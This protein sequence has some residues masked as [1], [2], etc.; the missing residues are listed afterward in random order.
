MVRVLELEDIEASLSLTINS[1]SL[2]VSNYNVQCTETNSDFSTYTYSVSSTPVLQSLSQQSV[3]AGDMLVI[4]LKGISETQNDNILL[5][6]GNTGLTCFSPNPPILSTVIMSP[7]TSVSTTAST[8]SDHTT[9]VHCT[10]P[11]LPAGMYRPLLHVAGRGWGQSSLESTVVTVHP[12]ITSSPSSAS[13]SLRGGL[14]LAMG[15]R[16][17]FDSDVLRTRVTIGNTPCRVESIDTEGMLTCFTQAAVDDGYSALIRASLPLAY[18]SLQTDYYRSNNS[19]LASD[20]LSFLRNSGSLGVRANASIHGSI[21]LRQEGISGNSLTDQ[22]IGFTE[23]AFLQVPALEE[24]LSPSGFAMDFWVRVPLSIQHYRIL[25]NASSSCEDAA[26]GFMV[27]L[28][29]CNQVE[30]WLASG[31]QFQEE[32]DQSGSG[33]DQFQEDINLFASGENLQQFLE[34]NATVCS[35]ISDVSQCSTSCSGYMDTSGLMLPTG[36]WHIIRSSPTNLSDWN[37]V[38]ISWKANTIRD[39]V[40]NLTSTDCMTT[41]VCNGMQEL[42]I[43]GEYDSISSTYQRANTGIEIGGSSSIALGTTG[44]WNGMA[45]FNGYIDEVAYYD[46][47]LELSEINSRVVH[48]TQET[49]PIVLTVEGF[50]GVGTGSVPNLI[51]TPTTNPPLP[52]EVINW[53][54]VV[55]FEYTYEDSVMLQFGWIQ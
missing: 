45:P 48:G 5:F 28:N 53:E 6:G 54:S 38:Y 52:P 39:S 40:N 17:L 47:P 33:V 27:M 43:N 29:P 16:G 51:Y 4:E 23:S 12:Q 9:V 18:W 26:C 42:I 20:G 8:Y 37:H 7:V 15:T 36:V 24:L 22:S 1:I 11:A 21:A 35:L 25:I 31:E 2:N 19:Y 30:F 41:G 34:D 50:D 13:G 14:S 32:D 46:K 10:V 55:D 44:V 3:V 49:Q